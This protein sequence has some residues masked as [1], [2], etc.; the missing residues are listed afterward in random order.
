[1]VWEN[2]PYSPTGASNWT[3]DLRKLQVRDIVDPGIHLVKMILDLLVKMV[4]S[5]FRVAQSEDREA[6]TKAQP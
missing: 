4:L 1:M 3:G 2:L 5:A 6:F